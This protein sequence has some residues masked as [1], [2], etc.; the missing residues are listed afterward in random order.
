MSDLI[1]AIREFGTS[2]SVKGARYVSIGNCQKN[3]VQTVDSDPEF[4][5][6]IEMV[7][8]LEKKNV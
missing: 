1:T 4:L 7:E 6:I 2:M 5:K 8:E 3:P